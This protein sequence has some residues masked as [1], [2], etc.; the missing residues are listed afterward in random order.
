MQHV[1]ISHFSAQTDFPS[2]NPCVTTVKQYTLTH[3]FSKLNIFKLKASY[4]KNNFKK[5]IEILF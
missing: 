2:C 1:L 3:G 4:E 5:F